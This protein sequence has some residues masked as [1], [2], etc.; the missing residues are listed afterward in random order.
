VYAQGTRGRCKTGTILCLPEFAPWGGAEFMHGVSL[1]R[2]QSAI[3]RCLPAMHR[4]ATHPHAPTFTTYSRAP[5]HHTK[6]D[7][8][9]LWAASEF[10]GFLGIMV[11]R[12]EATPPTWTS[13]PS[14]R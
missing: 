9:M 14:L 13:R 2:G 5:Y 10:L 4:A 7:G 12:L 8:S 1:M 3:Y 11:A 6:P